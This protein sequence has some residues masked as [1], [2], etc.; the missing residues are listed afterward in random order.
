MGL[1]A[2]GA[3]ITTRIGRLVSKGRSSAVGNFCNFACVMAAGDGECIHVGRVHP[4]AVAGGDR[5]GLDPGDS[6]PE[7]TRLARRGKI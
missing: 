2:T 1:L 4:R 3:T 7:G 5:R 6:R